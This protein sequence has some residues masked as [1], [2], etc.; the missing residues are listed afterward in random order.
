M[1]D[2]NYEFFGWFLPWMSLVSP[3]WMAW[4]RLERKSLS[5]LEFT[6]KRTFLPDLV[7]PRLM[8]LCT[9]DAAISKPR[10][11][12]PWVTSHEPR[13]AMSRSLRNVFV[14][15]RRMFLAIARCESHADYGGD[16]AALFVGRNAI[17]ASPDID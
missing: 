7:D 5:F 16:V 6:L 9:A 15:E 14:E 10:S 4:P 3:V 13:V 12:A 8:C 1:V 11:T 17:H 2:D